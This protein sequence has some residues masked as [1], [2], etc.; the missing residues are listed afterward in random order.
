MTT[1]PILNKDGSPVVDVL[2]IPWDPTRHAKSMKRNR[3]G[4]WR[5][6]KG[7]PVTTTAPDSTMTPKANGLTFHDFLAAGW[8][9][10]LLITHRYIH[11]PAPAPVKGDGTGQQ[12][13]RYRNFARIAGL[14]PSARAIPPSLDHLRGWIT[15]G[16]VPVIT[17][18]PYDWLGA[19]RGQF[20]EDATA[21][22]RGIPEHKRRLWAWR[23]VQY[24]SP[25]YPGRTLLVL[26]THAD[27]ARQLDTIAARL[28]GTEP[29]FEGVTP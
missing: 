29:P 8:T 16:R 24:P 25:Y 20:H 6:L 3:D 22:T 9:L 21:R 15:Y 2:G 11:A 4:T 12:K 17:S 23:T 18:E 7:A 14:K 10:P 26:L 1:A 28:E 13:A 27:C 5:R 19:A